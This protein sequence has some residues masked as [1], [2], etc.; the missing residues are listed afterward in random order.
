[1][2][3]ALSTQSH[4]D[5]P[6]WGVDRCLGCVRL[7]LLRVFGSVPPVGWLCWGVCACFVG[8]ALRY[9]YYGPGVPRP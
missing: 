3:H 5:S 7:S 1:M 8:V 9:P 2:N 6:V 4:P